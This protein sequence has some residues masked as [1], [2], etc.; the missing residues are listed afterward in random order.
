M[1][2]LL[3]RRESSSYDGISNLASMEVFKAET[4]TWELAPSMNAHEGGVGVGVVPIPPNL[5][6]HASP[7]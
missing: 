7:C 2:P 4:E 6:A 1:S 5:L 3:V